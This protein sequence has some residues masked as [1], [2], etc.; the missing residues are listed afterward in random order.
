M[1]KRN[2]GEGT[3]YYSAA[4]KQWIGQFTKT[5]AGEKIRK[6]V[7]GATKNE[8][9]EKLLDLRVE[10]KDTNFIKE[11]GMPLIQIMELIR[12]KKYNSNKIKDGQYSRITK[13]IE[14]IQCSKIGKMNVKDITADD[15]Q[16]FLNDNKE[17]SNSTIKKLYEQFNQAFEYA[18]RNKYIKDN[19]MRDVIKPKSI[20]QDKEVRALTIDEQKE[21]SDYLFKSSI[22]D[23]KYKNVFLIQMYLGLRIGE[24]LALTKNDI[25][26]PQKLLFVNRTTTIGKNGETIIGDSTKTYAGK[27]SVPIPN[28]M[29]PIFKEQI[30]ISKNNRDNYL[31]LNDDKLITNSACNSR[32]KRIINDIL[33]WQNNSFSS[34]SLRHTFA[35]RCIESGVNAVVLQR[36][37]GHTDISITLNTYTSVFNL[38]KDN[39][40]EKVI[41]LYKNNSLGMI[42]AD[43]TE[44]SPRENFKTFDE[45]NN[46]LSMIQ[47]SYTEKSQN[48]TEEIYLDEE[49]DEMEF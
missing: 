5:V 32:L 3:I 25:D 13:T 6:S 47:E 26:L 16:D 9:S 31:F 49:D 34:H 33:G 12:D 11:K 18:I 39:E 42:Q 1:A 38:F 7:Y 40:L 45:K 19:P 28:F 44:N 30:E 24:A 27:R 46:S 41:E 8:V 15:I 43:Y 10:M 48:E 23:E 14:K 20:K 2:R 17:Y 36:L 35:T 4:R 29:I 21:L 37:L 22:K